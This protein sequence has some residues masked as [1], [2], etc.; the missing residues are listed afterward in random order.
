MRLVNAHEAPD[1]AG[2]DVAPITVDGSSLNND[3][4]ENEEQPDQ[5]PK[6]LPAP[7]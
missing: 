3:G 6:S 7:A 4:V 2:A 1:L 5:P